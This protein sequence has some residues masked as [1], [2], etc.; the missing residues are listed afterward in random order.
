MKSISSEQ[1][2]YEL[3]LGQ[4][5]KTKKDKKFRKEFFNGDSEKKREL[6]HCMKISWKELFEDSDIKWYK[7]ELSPNTDFV[8][9]IFDSGKGF[10]REIGMTHTDL[11]NEYKSGKM[12]EEFRKI[13]DS[14]RK[15]QKDMPRVIVLTNDMKTYTI[16]DG[17][18]RA[19]ALRLDNKKISVYLGYKSKFTSLKHFN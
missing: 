12:H 16:L 2:A 19:L 6:C 14:V 3:A 4:Q 9:R 15:E 1:V 7:T 11:E 5:R 17:A 13:I 18:R 8:N 10:M